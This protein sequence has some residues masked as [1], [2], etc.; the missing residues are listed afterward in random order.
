VQLTDLE[1][2]QRVLSA[3]MHSDDACAEAITI[4]DELD[5]TDLFHAQVFS[6]SRTIYI[7]N[8]RPTIAELLKQGLDT[9]LVVGMESMERLKKIS[10]HY[11][12]DDN[13]NFWVSKVKTK[14]KVRQMDE[15]LTKYKQSLETAIDADAENI[16]LQA[17]N[18]FSTLSLTDAN[19]DIQEPGEVAKLGYNLVVEKMEAY[20]KHK[21]E[22]PYG[23]P[24]LDGVP[25][26]IPSLDVITM[27]YKPGDLILLG[28]KTGHGKTAFALNTVN[29]VAVNNNSP[30]LYINTEMSKKQ[31][32]LRW[33]S[34]LSGIKHDK[35]RSG[36]ITNEE[37]IQIG[38]AYAKLEQSQFYPA[39][40]PNL[41]PAKQQS[42]AR[43]AKIRKNVELIILDYVGRMET[44]DPK[45]QEWQVLKEIVRAQKILAQNLQLACL[46][47]VQLNPDGSIQGA[48]Q[49]ANDCDMILKLIPIDQE[50]IK[51][52]Q[53]RQGVIYD[54]INYKLEIEKNRDG[55]AG[56]SIPIWFDKETQQVSQ[57]LVTKKVTPGAQSD[58]SDIGKEVKK[59]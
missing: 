5:F 33:G 37:L 14:S 51:D 41:T 58:F 15:M 18:E 8:I 47:L 57:A 29:A 12:D 36:G 38:N 22:N 44:Y 21:N 24:L 49:I 11:I 40:I 20:R 1:S 55:Q 43:K 25:T 59:K 32:A 27:G 30:V 26:G 39:T 13:I 17:S 50:E 4:L 46:V 6:L 34:I 19:E 2:E 52:I 16:I 3:M 9:G 56:G 42:L 48:K 53:A 35:I 28:A 23:P 10:E 31:I 45:R 54:H 7:K